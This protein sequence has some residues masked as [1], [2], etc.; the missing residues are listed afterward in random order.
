MTMLQPTFQD[1]VVFDNN[2]TLQYSQFNFNFYSY[3]LNFGLV[4]ESNDMIFRD[5]L[6]RN[7]FDYA[8]PYLVL[9]NLVQ[10][11]TPMTQQII[12]YVNFYSFTAH[13][14][15]LGSIFASANV[16]SNQDLLAQQFDLIY[17]TEEQLPRMQDFYFD[18]PDETNCKY[19]FLLKCFVFINQISEII[20]DNQ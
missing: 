14:G 5:F 10:Y 20:S 18:D 9:P 12:D 16:I 11:F 8:Q 2:K 1:F 13:F 6:Q 4:G 7:N 15:Y 3:A 19:N 17:Y